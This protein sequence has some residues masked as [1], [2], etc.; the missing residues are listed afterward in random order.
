[1]SSFTS[2][3]TNFQ[4]NH[5]RDLFEALDG[6][7]GATIGDAEIFLDNV[8]L[9]AKVSARLLAK[10]FPDPEAKMKFDEFL[11]NLSQKKDQ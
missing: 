5:L 10:G 11:R 6:Q 9:D 7:G 2:D 3:L 1:M 8:G 4:V